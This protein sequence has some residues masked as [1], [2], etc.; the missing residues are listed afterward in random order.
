MNLR[1][2]WKSTGA[3]FATIIALVLMI[4]G[5][6]GGADATLPSIYRGVYNGTWADPASNENGTFT[7]TVFANGSITGNMSSTQA[8]STAPMS[9]EVDQTGNF[10]MIAGFGA[11]GNFVMN[12]TMVL[13]DT[14]LLGS[15]EYQFLG[16]TYMGSFTTAKQGSSTGGSSGSTGN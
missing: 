6:G 2:N 13:V 16:G 5:C 3:G 10:E 15:F 1:R 8:G 14:S 4:I 7:L 12:G 9:G 11:S